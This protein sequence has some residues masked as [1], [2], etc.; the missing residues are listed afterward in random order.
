MCGIAGTISVLP[1]EDSH[2]NDVIST[3]SKRG[4]DGTQASEFQL[5]NGACARFLFSRLAI[6]DLDNRAMQPMQFQEFIIM[7]NGEIYNYKELKRSLEEKFG[8]QDWKTS[9]DVEVALR[10]LY[11]NGID[12]AR[13]FDGMFAISLLDLRKDKLYLI[14]DFFGEK[15]LYF[16]STLNL[17]YFASEP[18]TIWKLCK[19]KPKLNIAKLINYVINGYKAIYKDNEQ[20][21]AELQEVRAGEIVEFL[22]HELLSK[23]PL[24]PPSTL[25][26]E[27]NAI[28]I[29]KDILTRIRSAVI[30]SVGRRLE[31]DVPLA[32]CLSGGIDSGL[33]AAI[34]KK[35]FG[36]SLNA[37]TLISKDER[38]SELNSSKEIASFLNLEHHL[39]HVGKVNFIE[40]LRELIR[41]HEAPIS[42]ISYYVQSFLLERIHKDGF[43]VSLM[44][45][46]ADELFTGYYDHHLLYLYELWHKHPSEH[47]AAL[48]HW[49][50]KILPLVRNP[51]YRNADLYIREPEFREHIFNSL[52]SLKN[53]DSGID[54][55]EFSE[56]S[57]SESLLRN[58]MLNE[59]FHEVVPVILKE[60]DR[61]SMFY[62]V[63]NRSPFLSVD[64]LIECLAV[65]EIHLIHQGRTKS[66]L[67]EAFDGYLPENILY[68]HRKIGFNA[69]FLELCDVG[70]SDFRMFL[71]DHSTFWNFI[72]K[73]EAIKIFKSIHGSDN[74]NKAA[75]SLASAKVF[76][77]E[78]NS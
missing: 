66:L 8:E 37:Y 1:I 75:F 65:D 21:F 33:I 36:V 61:N 9:G 43:K 59:L 3:L 50:K 48:I 72:N 73:E 62:S 57:Y 24:F 45:T 64:L 2:Q 55:K 40:R 74:N 52:E 16:L 5:S 22:K 26:I 42:T 77:E 51:I 41:Y 53:Q 12:S 7:L 25:R 58:R 35:D 29:R 76:F 47:A 32:L 30:R 60:D 11:F 69:G 14:R 18:K 39:V 34:A 54:T 19:T 20:F 23:R 6:I 44:G 38:Y 17:L 15:P 70:S 78:F 68:S 49:N 63:E 67:R 10:Y 4:P 71:D 27:P 46:G 31:S 13:D 56:N 28:L